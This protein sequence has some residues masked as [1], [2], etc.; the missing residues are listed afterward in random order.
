MARFLA[1][2]PSVYLDNFTSSTV[3][4]VFVANEVPVRDSF[5]AD[6]ATTVAL[7]IISTTGFDISTA[8]GTQEIY[9][10]GVLAFERTGGGSPTFVNGFS[11]GFSGSDPRRHII[12]IVPPAD[13]SSEQVVAVRVVAEDVD[14]PATTVDFTYSFTVE[15][16]TT[17][18]LLQVDQP[19]PLV[20]RATFDE[21]M[22]AQ[23]TS[24]T[25]DALNPA[26]YSVTFEPDNDRQ[27]GVS[28]V[29][30]AITQVSAT[31]YDLTLDIEP[32]FFRT[33]RLTVGD[34]A[35]DSLAGNTVALGD[36]TLTFTSWSPPDWPDTRDF[37]LWQMMSKD[38]RRG[39]VHGDL[40]R[41]LSA[42]DDSLQVMC[43]DIDQWIKIIDID[44]APS[45]FVDAIL[46]DLGNPFQFDLT[47]NR[48]RKLADLL[49]EIYKQR[50]T[51][52]GIIN[53]A[54]FFLGIEITSIDIFNEEM[55][56]LGESEL[57]I[58][59]DLGPSAQANLYTFVVTVDQ[60]LDAETEKNLERLIRL[61][62]VAHE[63]FQIKTPSDALV[64]DHLELGFSELGVNWILH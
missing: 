9:V 27:A 4:A 37:S 7:D 46:A 33:Y 50:G 12:T 17:P 10:A 62:K 35:D 56:I 2:L 5:G 54:R 59:T 19:G 30:T 32:T 45:Q 18:K 47:D 24:G 43:W 25:N 1:E 51:P 60:E 21:G 26:N 34:I 57:G 14:A 6:T 8:D 39:D 53:L 44:D 64:I 42:L 55:W 40:E 3:A 41:I 31:V 13:F 61:T 15:D 48:K 23:S 36:N 58:D 38:D 52:R 63:H 49:P 16:L 22:L 28:V 29:V 11:G 20:V